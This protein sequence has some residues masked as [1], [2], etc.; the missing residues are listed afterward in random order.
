MIVGPQ[1]TQKTIKQTLTILKKI[2]PDEIR[3][4]FQ[5]DF[6]PNGLNLAAEKGY[7][8]SLHTDIPIIPG[9]L[10]IENQFKA[11]LW[12]LKSFYQSQEWQ[13]HIGKKIQKFDKL[14]APFK[15]YKEHLKFLNIL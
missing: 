10:S 14:D 15:K 13:K 5:V 3:I 7:L 6:S 4:S 1:D 11:R 9:K 2:L 12:L 8:S